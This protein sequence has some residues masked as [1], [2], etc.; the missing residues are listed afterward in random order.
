MIE[1][2]HAHG[3]TESLFIE[4][5]RSTVKSQPFHDHPWYPPVPIAKGG[6]GTCRHHGHPWPPE[7]RHV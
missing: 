2:C 3:D 5:C 4:L 6:D 1:P 7:H